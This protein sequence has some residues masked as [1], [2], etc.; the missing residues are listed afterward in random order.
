M[1]AIIGEAWDQAS[2]D[3]GAPFMG[4]SGRLLKSALSSVGIRY[5]DCF[6]TCVFNL[7][8]QPTT[9]IKN[10]CGPRTSGIPGMPQLAAGKFVRSEYAS[11]LTRLYSDLSRMRP[12][13]ILA[14]GATACWALGVDHR[15]KKTRGAPV[16]SRFG[17]VF[18]TL[19]PSSIFRDWS[20]RPVFY[21]DMNK[22]AKEM[23][24]PDVRRPRREIWVEPTL[25]DLSA[26]EA[27][28]I[29]G[30]PKL[31]IDIETSGKYITCVGFAPSTERCLVVPFITAGGKPYWKTSTEEISAWKWVKHVCQTHPHIIGQNFLYDAHRLWRSYGITTPGLQDDTMLLHHSLFIE[32]EKG[33]G[34]LGSIYT[35]EARWKFMRTETLKKEDE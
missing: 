12:T 4:A 1:L 31:S 18:P 14:L 22:V 34:F 23:E 24:F 28:Y 32:L 10:L 35:S 17:K 13:M 7:M 26:F 30:S 29:I 16:M 2:K 27:S 33:L 5:N 19:N 6:V 3:A 25:E 8:P 20:N 15:L 9:D 11:E 21:A